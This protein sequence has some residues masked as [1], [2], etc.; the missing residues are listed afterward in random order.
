MINLFLVPVLV[1]ADHWLAGLTCTRSISY[2]AFFLSA[3]VE[4][5]KQSVEEGGEGAGKLS[6]DK[7]SMQIC[8]TTGA[9]LFGSCATGILL[10]MALANND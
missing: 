4:V 2:S 6:G 7:A 8:K 9:C 5:F 1:G 10:M 3:I